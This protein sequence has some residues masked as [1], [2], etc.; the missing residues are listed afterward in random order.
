MDQDEMLSLF[1]EFRKEIKE[2]F[3][4]VENIQQLQNDRLARLIEDH[5]FTRQEIAILKVKSGVWGTIGGAMIILS[6]LLAN[7]LF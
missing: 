6:A 4:T 1:Y 5:F 3:K 2:H 7:L